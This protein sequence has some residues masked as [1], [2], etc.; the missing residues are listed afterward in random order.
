MKTLRIVTATVLVLAL[1]AAGAVAAEPAVSQQGQVPQ[2]MLADLG[3]GD[4]QM[5]SDSEGQQVRGKWIVFGRFSTRAL[6]TLVYKAS[7]D[8]AVAINV[9][10]ALNDANVAVYKATGR[11]GNP[12][13]GR[14]SLFP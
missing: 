10:N 14:F 9:M 5:M 3:L 1:F 2:E 13:N 7:H 4:M 11:T 12:V 6:T 8:K